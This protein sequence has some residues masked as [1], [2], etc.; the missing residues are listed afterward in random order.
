MKKLLAIVLVLALIFTL[1]Y[2]SAEKSEDFSKFLAGLFTDVSEKIDNREIDVL[3]D[4]YN[5]RYNYYYLSLNEDEKYVYSVIYNSY[6]DMKES[7]TV[8][9]NSERYNYINNCV[10]YD[11]PDIFWVNPVYK[12][13]EYTSD[14]TVTPTYRNTESSIKD[15]QSQMDSKVSEI[16]NEAKKCPTAFEK[17]LFIH[18]YICNIAEYDQSTYDTIGDTAYSALIN[19]KCICEGYCRAFKILLDGCGI[20]NYMVTGI[21]KT[22]EGEEG[23]MW[24]VVTID[25]ENYYVDI[26]WDDGDEK[27][28]NTTH[29]YFNMNEQDI[30]KEHCDLVPSD[31]N[32]RGIMSNFF[33]KRGLFI[34]QPDTGSESFIKTCVKEL[35]NNGIV[36]L[37]F[38]DAGEYNRFKDKIA[39]SDNE[40]FNLLE[41]LNAR[42][43]RKIKTNTIHYIS[44][45]CYLYI[46]LMFEEG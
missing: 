8:S 5:G 18:D 11:N 42:S 23:H 1:I 30:V 28:I 45:D 21:G 15:I 6:T 25:S 24:N 29:L 13:T 37:K 26:T 14:I 7:F 44:N 31:N 38:S 17:E 16:I 39:N 27:L 12:Y 36:E 22:S 41:K 20:N 43:Q 4:N 2:I 9:T 10:L 40:I 32:C 3:P 46:C 19:G 35:E 33:Y 34:T